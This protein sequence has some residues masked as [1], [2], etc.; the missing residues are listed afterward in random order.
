M[1]DAPATARTTGSI[2]LLGIEPLEQHARRLAA[3][4]TVSHGRRLGGTSH[5]KALREH[6]RA[7]RAAYT[8]LAEDATR[9][10]PSSPAAEWLLDNFHIVIAALRDITH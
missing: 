8:S 10:E 2:E 7:L 9:G 4:L 5:L 6:S 1:R 3:L